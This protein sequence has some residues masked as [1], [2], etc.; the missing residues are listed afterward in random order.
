MVVAVEHP[1]LC[2]LEPETF[3]DLVP[4]LSTEGDCQNA[5]H[6]LL[7][8]FAPNPG[9][10]VVPNLGPNFD[11]GPDPMHFDPSSGSDDS[12]YSDLATATVIEMRIETDWWIGCHHFHLRALA[13]VF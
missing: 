1:K 9:P 10:A 7:M 4:D 13:C 3:D 6:G 8:H 5:H 11:P 12:R 2:P